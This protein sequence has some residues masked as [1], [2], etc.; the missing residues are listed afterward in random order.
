MPSC[1]YEVVP[2]AKGTEMFRV[3]RGPRGAKVTKLSPSR[4]GLKS[5]PSIRLQGASCVTKLSPSRRGLK[6]DDGCPIL[7]TAWLR[8]C[9]LR[10]GD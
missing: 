10:E 7:S 4:R 6:C 3:R 9:P 5:K 2:F 1:C 8:S